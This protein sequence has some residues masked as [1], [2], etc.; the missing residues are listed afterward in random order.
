MGALSTSSVID[1]SRLPCRSALI[2]Q[3]AISRTAS[4]KTLRLAGVDIT[5]VNRDGVG[6]EASPG[7]TSG[8]SPAAELVA[9]R[10]D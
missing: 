7:P 9:K 6:C 1:R 10:F 4:G 8:V 2:T 5:A 3:P